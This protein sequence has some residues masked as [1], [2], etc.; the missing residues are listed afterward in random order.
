MRDVVPPGWTAPPWANTLHGLESDS[1]GTRWRT[2]HHSTRCSH[3]EAITT[4][5][6]GGVWQLLFTFYAEFIRRP[7]RLRDDEDAWNKARQMRDPDD[8]TADAQ[9]W[10][11][12]YWNDLHNPHYHTA[13]PTA[14]SWHNSDLWTLLRMNPI[15]PGTPG[16]EALATSEATKLL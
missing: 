2:L 10:D 13:W 3:T 16:T 5:R 11:K 7:T 6:P 12:D 8:V 15:I 14:G 9:M 4:F 1:P